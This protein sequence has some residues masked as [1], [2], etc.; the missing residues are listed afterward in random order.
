MRIFM[1][2][3]PSETEPRQ[4]RRKKSRSSGRPHFPFPI[5]PFPHFPFQWLCEFDETA[6]RDEPFSIPV[7]SGCRQVTARMMHRRERTFYFD[8]ATFQMLGLPYDPQHPGQ[9]R[10]AM[11]VFL[12]KA[13]DGLPALEAALTAANLEQWSRAVR[14]GEVQIALPRFKIH[15]CTE[16]NRAFLA[17]GL[18]SAFDKDR[19]DFSGMADTIEPFWLS[20]ALQ[21]TVCRVDEKGTEAASA[22]AGLV[23]AGTPRVPP[24]FRADH[25][26]LFLI[27]DD[28]SGAILFLGR[29]VN[30]AET[31]GSQGKSSGDA[32]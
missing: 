5:S 10:L 1:T 25:P 2:A 8:G 3:L 13:V 4:T 32:S 31:D 14:D 19:A 7:A 6:T 22:F 15:A 30:P 21:R 20:S 17:M 26:F 11:W 23:A 18:Q 29:V 28:D 24:V 27:R 9:R 16:L 12:P